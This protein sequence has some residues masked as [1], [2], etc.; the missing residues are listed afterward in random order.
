MAKT[1]WK[2]VELNKDNLVRELKEQDEKIKAIL[3]RRREVAA[4]TKENGCYDEVWEM[5]YADGKPHYEF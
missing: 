3:E 4:I 1:N 5:L 2:D